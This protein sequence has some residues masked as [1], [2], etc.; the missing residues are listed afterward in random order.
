MPRKI[1]RR[2]PQRRRGRAV[3]VEFAFVNLTKPSFA[4][5]RGEMLSST[6]SNSLILTITWAGA[7]STRGSHVP[8]RLQYLRACYAY[9]VQT[10]LALQRAYPSITSVQKSRERA[11]STFRLI[12]SASSTDLHCKISDC[13]LSLITLCH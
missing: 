12:A 8:A 9:S 10:P 7:H 2:C 13:F 6:N 5:L 4:D 3:E 1:G 11:R